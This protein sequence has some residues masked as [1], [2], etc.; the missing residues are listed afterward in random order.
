MHT[1]PSIT[2]IPTD[3]LSWVDT[4]ANA[5]TVPTPASFEAIANDAGP[6]PGRAYAWIIFSTLAAYFVNAAIQ[7]LFYGTV[8]QGHLANTLYLQ[9]NPNTTMT[10]ALCG[11][12]VA[13]VSTLFAVIIDAAVMR[14]SS[15]I[16]K[17]EGTYNK[18]VYVTAAFISPLVIITAALAA[19]PYVW[20]LTIPIGLYAVYLNVVTVKA[21]N[22]FDW[23]KA[24]L[25]GVVFPG[26]LSLVVG[27]GLM[28]LMI[29][30]SDL[31]MNFIRSAV[32]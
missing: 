16:L 17:G 26:T 20:L 19:I 8:S 1:D 6:N 28:L 2:E 22:G 32:R 18:L 30:A 29:A 7:L 15:R 11:A 23:K 3:H 5:L 24:A 4:W 25:A 21:V 12:P 9:Y 13:A 14:I 10:L 31:L 27:L